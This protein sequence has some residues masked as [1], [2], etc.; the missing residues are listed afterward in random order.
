MLKRV[1]IFLST[2]PLLLSTT[3]LSAIAAET[4]VLITPVRMPIAEP[5]ANGNFTMKKI[6]Q[7]GVPNHWDT[8]KEYITWTIFP[9]APEKI[10]GL[11]VK[12][13]QTVANATGFSFKYIDSSNLPAPKTYKEAERLNYA[14]IQMYYG[15]RSS[16][17]GMTAIVNAETN[18]V[19]GGGTSE[20]NGSY[21]ESHRETTG[22]V[23]DFAYP[24]DDFTKKGL[25]IVMLH[26]LGHAM[27]LGHAKGNGDVMGNIKPHDGTFGPGDLTGLYKLSA[28]I[29]CAKRLTTPA[30]TTPSVKTITCVKG[31]LQRK[32]TAANPVCPKGYKEK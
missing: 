6:D 24:A 20:W 7:N 26:E 32:V 8:C 9:G 31:A 1:I 10:Y 25:G 21:F 29:P 14:E 28:G 15:V 13:F 27:G 11:A 23:T 18:G 16:F 19:D 3:T 22:Q 2:L 17:V 5:P 30:S 4:S 12:N